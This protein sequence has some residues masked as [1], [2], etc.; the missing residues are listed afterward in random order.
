MRNNRRAWVFREWGRRMYR[1]RW[2][3]IF[4]WIFLFSFSAYFIQGLPERLTDSGFTPRGSESDLGTIAMQEQLGTSPSILHITYQSKGVD[5][6]K[7]EGKSMILGSLAH[8]NEQ[9]YVNKV[10]INETPRIKVDKQFQSAIVEL[11]ISETEALEKFPDIK[12]QIKT[13]ENMD[14][15]VDGG[16]ATLYEIQQATKK[17]MAKAEMIG[18][19]IALVVL[20][21]IFGTFWGALLPLI[22]GIVSVSV[23]LGITYFIAGYYSLSN[24]LPNVV[25]MIGLA[26]GIDYALFIV[27]RFRDEL[28]QNRSVEDAVAAASASA[29]QSVFFSGFAVLIGMF[30]MLFI[31]LPIL[32]ALCLGGVLVV[33]AAMVVSC[34]LLLS[35]LGIIGGNINSLRVLPVLQTKLSSFSFWE[36]MARSVISRPLILALLVSSFLLTLMLPIKDMILDVPTA[37]VLPPVY[38]SRIGADLLK[39]HYDSREASP[40][41]VLV[42]LERNYTEAA[43]IIEMESLES[44]FKKIAGVHAV[45]SYLGLLKGDTVQQKASSLQSHEIKKLVTDNKL[46]KENFAMVTVVPEF[47]PDSEKSM[48]LVDRLRAIETGAVSNMVTGEAAIKADILNRIFD[49]LPFLMVFIMSIT[50]VV[51]LFAFKSVLIPL[52]AVAMNILSLGASLGIVVLVFQKGWLAQMLEITSTGYVSIIMPVTIFCIVFG[53]SMDYEVFL[54]SSMMEEYE[55]TGD[56]DQSTIAGLEKTGG[57][58]SSAAFILLVVVGS[59]IFTDIEITKS[60]GVGLFCAIF[61]D[62]TLIRII[63]VPALMK[64]LG[65]ANWW[66][67]KWLGGR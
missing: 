34:T 23:T 19:P 41:L 45:R 14:V 16:I 12:K 67:P 27:S 57:L 38:E 33:L 24:F 62:A 5:L 11:K 35:L 6:T 56:N 28:K 1:F 65:H 4:C 61:I 46:A 50:Y 7:K 52:K 42:N 8:L 26:L 58:I 10:Y 63:I 15:Y 17:D 3:I 29:G 39:E 25:V 47:D 44:K 54:I 59:F 51:L 36:K 64:L 32:Y 20:L 49:G 60:L 66:A 2:Q 55:K 31:K 53:I 22:I 48:Q 9:D 43:S 40:L 30:G 21:F 18:I 37:E 13:P